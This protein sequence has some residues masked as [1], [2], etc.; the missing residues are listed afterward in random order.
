MSET[1]IKPGDFVKIKSPDFFEDYKKNHPEQQFGSKFFCLS[2]RAN[3]VQTVVEIKDD[4]DTG[5][6]YALLTGMFGMRYPLEFI[7]GPLE[8]NEIND[9]RFLRTIDVD[10][11]WNRLPTDYKRYFLTW[12]LKAK[13]YD[14]DMEFGTDISSWFEK[15]FGKENLET[16][17]ENE[18]KLF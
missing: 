13:Q 18:I 12:Y 8:V 7:E 2:N 9:E 3:E 14:K 6:T 16:F 4:P 1:N 11:H 15:M 10:F 17:K 5:E